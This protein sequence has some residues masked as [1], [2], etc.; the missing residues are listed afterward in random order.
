[1]KVFLVFMFRIGKD[2]QLTPALA[3]FEGPTICI[4]YRWISII[5]NIDNTNF[6]LKGLKS[7][8][9]F[10]QISITGGSVGVGFNC[11]S[12]LEFVFTIG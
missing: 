4:C 7:G 3:D 10:R 8:F 6:V 5:A 1:M 11:I 12:F 9:R 2:V